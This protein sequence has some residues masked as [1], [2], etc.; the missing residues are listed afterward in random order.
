MQVTRQRVRWNQAELISNTADNVKV[1]VE[2]DCADIIF[3]NLSN[4]NGGAGV[5]YLVNQMPVPPG[6]TITFG[7]NQNEYLTGQITVQGPNPLGNAGLWVQ[8]KKY[9]D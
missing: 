1:G 2:T 7:C 5:I 3:T 4:V 8:R 6:G 9:V